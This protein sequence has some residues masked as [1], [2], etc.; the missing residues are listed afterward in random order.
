[1]RVDWKIPA[2]FQGFDVI[3]NLF[4]YLSVLVASLVNGDGDAARE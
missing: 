4:I 3:C 2:N 1:M